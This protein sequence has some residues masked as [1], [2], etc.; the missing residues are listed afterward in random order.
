M[1]K[2]DFH[3]WHLCVWEMNP[4]PTRMY[5]NSSTGESVV[6]VTVAIELRQSRRDCFLVIR[7]SLFL[8]AATI[9]SSTPWCVF[10]EYRWQPVETQ[11][12]YFQMYAMCILDFDKLGNHFISFRPQK[13]CQ[14]YGSSDAICC[15]IVLHTQPYLKQSPRISLK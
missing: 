15:Q 10:M 3:A 8:I 4:C 1:M 11:F 2:T 7:R 14:R 5:W 6:P 13:Q 9:L 12:C